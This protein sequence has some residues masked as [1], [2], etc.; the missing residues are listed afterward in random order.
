MP[1]PVKDDLY[2]IVEAHLTKDVADQV[3]DLID[4]FLT[5]TYTEAVSLATDQ[6]LNAVYLR[7]YGATVEAN[8]DLEQLILAAL[9]S[10]GSAG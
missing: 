6:L 5:K 7:K 8:G 9:T 1:N 4:R 2:N 3:N 10:S